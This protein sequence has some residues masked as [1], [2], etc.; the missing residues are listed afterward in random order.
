MENLSNNEV[1]EICHQLGMSYP[2]SIKQIY[3]GNIHNSWEI[4]FK[5]KKFFIKRN[6]RQ[7][8]LLKF[9]EYCLRNL[10]E[11]INNE[12]LTI[13]KVI[14]YLELLDVELLVMEWI[15]MKTV[16]KQS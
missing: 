5:K 4:E 6:K 14:L 11:H 16:I 15:D 7:K 1:S 9:E 13:P 8:K 3:G 10:Q 2:K 12:N